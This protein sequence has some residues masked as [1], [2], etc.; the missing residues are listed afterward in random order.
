MTC[1]HNPVGVCPIAINGMHVYVYYYRCLPEAD[2]AD[3]H[4][5][6][7]DSHGRADGYPSGRGVGIWMRQKGPPIWQVF[8]LTPAAAAVRF[9]GS[10]ISWE[11]RIL[12]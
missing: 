3:T 6:T 10:E 11:L 2:R 9:N 5:T 7:Y 1:D 12:S 4:T 8:W